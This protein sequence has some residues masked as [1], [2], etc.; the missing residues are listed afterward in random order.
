MM[1]IR[2]SL[3]RKF[4]M[5]RTASSWKVMI[6]PQP[7]SGNVMVIYLPTCQPCMVTKGGGGLPKYDNQGE[8]PEGNPNFTD[9]RTSVASHAKFTHP[10]TDRNKISKFMSRHS[11]GRQVLCHK[12]VKQALELLEAVLQGEDNTGVG[13]KRVRHRR[14]TDTPRKRVR[15]SEDD[16]G[17]TPGESPETR[18]DENARICQ[19]REL[20]SLKLKE[21]NK[22]DG[23][24]GLNNVHCVRGRYP[25]AMV[26]AL[27]RFYRRQGSKNVRPV[28]DAEGWTANHPRPEDIMAKWRP[29]SRAQAES[30]PGIIKGV[31]RQKWSGLV[32]K[33]FG[34]Q[35]GVVATKAFGK[36]SILCD[37]HG[38][39]ITGAEG[40]E[41]A[42]T[43]DQLGNLFFF[44]NMALTKS[45]SMRRLSPATTDTEKDD[46]ICFDHGIKKRTFRG[47]IEELE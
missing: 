18:Q 34:E 14:K 47:E 23:F 12:L 26:K 38:K 8:A 39:V 36:G 40:R 16:F 3:K 11:D 15:A 10:E 19:A 35:K 4:A 37:F 45:A 33:A 2:K 42:E 32:V 1:S 13:L 6:P 44:S 25:D 28:I 43:Q 22:T 17:T 20:S 7:I 24:I 21:T 27:D 5:H 41:M 9:V 31:T 29:L 30:D 46:K